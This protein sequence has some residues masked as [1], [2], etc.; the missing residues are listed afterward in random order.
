MKL[1]DEIYSDLREAYLRYFDTA[2]YLRDEALMRER[3][4]LLDRP[5][6]VF[7]DVQLEP[8]LPYPS[9]VRLADVAT[10]VGVDQRVA[11]LVGEALFGDFFKGVPVSLRQH[12]AEALRAAMQPANAPGRHPV[13]TSGTGSGKTESFLLP[14]L[15]RL[16][17]EA[18]GW[19]TQPTPHP[20]WRRP[21]SVA[22]WRSLRADET[23]PAA[24]R[25]VILYPTNALVEDQMTRLRRA[26]RSLRGEG[27]PLWFGRYT[28]AT[29]GSGQPPYR[30]G[31]DGTYKAVAREVHEIDEELTVLRRAA[32]GDPE[33]L[34]QFADPLD[35]EMICRW[36]MLADP[37]DILVT[38]YSM[39]DVMMMREREDR[40]WEQTR[41]WL[42][43]DRAHVFN[44]VVDELH[45][46]RGTAGSEVALIIRML[47]MRLGLEPDSPQLRCL[48]SSASLSAEDAGK[49]YL[50]A[51]FG[52]DA[53]SFT[54]LPGQPLH[55]DAPRQIDAAA[56]QKA[57]S[58]GLPALRALAEEIN[59]PHAVAQACRDTSG[60][61]RAT[62]SAVI[63][64]RLFGTADEV[65]LS[66]LLRGA[67]AL[68]LQQRIPL[69][70]H[71]LVRQV[72]GMWACCD[73]VCP[74]VGSRPEGR[75]PIGRLYDR[76]VTTC[77]CGGRVLELLY[78]FEC[79][80][81]S[82]GGFVTRDLGAD[83]HLLS[84]GPIGV[85]SG[86]TELVFRRTADAFVWYRPGE[87]IAVGE[88]W[89]AIG[90]TFSFSPAALNPRL[91]H[92]APA[93]GDPTG[94]VLVSKGKVEEGTQ[95]P[96]L[97]S[98]C[99]ACGAREKQER[100]AFQQGHVRS[101]IRAHTTGR[102][103]VTQLLLSQLFRSAGDTPQES[104]TI[105]F[106]DSRDDAAKTAAGVALNQH[107]DTLRQVVRQVLR[108]MEPPIAIYE[109]VAGFQGTSEDMAFVQQRPEVVQA[110]MRET[111]GAGSPEDAD[112]LR[113]AREELGKADAVSWSALVARLSRELLGIGVNPAGP[114]A[115]VQRLR[116][117]GA[118]W[119]RLH[120][121]PVDGLWHQ[122]PPEAVGDDRY[123]HHTKAAALAADAAFD[124]GDRDIESIG[125][126][127]VEPVVDIVAP[128]FPGQDDESRLRMASELLASAVRIIGFSRRY[129]GARGY[130]PD[131]G[132]TPKKP[133]RLTNY[134]KRVAARHSL[135]QEELE[136]WV[137][138]TLGAV[139]PDWALPVEKSDAR[140]RVV[141]GDP[142]SRRSC[143]RCGTTHL[144]GSAGGCVRND[145]SGTLVPERAGEEGDYYG[146]L[147]QRRPRRLAIAELTGQTKPLS[148]QRRRQRRFRG[149]L[150]PQPEE[151]SLTD[152]LDVL[153][154]TTT[155]EVG[156]DIGS[157]RSV[158][159]ANV[160]PQR[161]NYQQRV[162]RAG[163]QGQAFSYAL[164][165]CRD[166]SHDD[167]YFTKPERMTGDE[168]PQPFLDLGRP[169]IIR[170]VA[171]S[172]L[173][174]RAF[175]SLPEPPEPDAGSV[176]G[177]FGKAEAWHEQYR[178]G[179]AAWLESASDVDQVVDRLSAGTDLGPAETRGL[180]DELRTS[181]IGEIDRA[182]ANPYFN[183]PE[184]SE[185]LAN[186]GVLPMFGF[187]TKVRPL[188]GRRPRS[189]RDHDS[190]VVA[191]RPLEQAVTMFSPGARVVKDKQV[192]TVVG[193]AD[194]AMAGRQSIGKDPLGDPLHLAFCNSCGAVDK[195]ADPE[196]R[197]PRCK[198][199]GE[200]AAGFKMF[201][202]RGFRTDHNPRDFDDSHDDLYFEAEPRLAATEETTDRFKRGGMAWH[203][204]E[205][206]EVV[207][208]NDN[209]RRLFSMWVERD[210]SVRV[211][212]DPYST[213]K[214]E[215]EGLRELD[216]AAI[217][218]VRP[219]DVAII[220]LDGIQLEDGLLP[221]SGELP[222]GYAAMWSFAEML[223]RGIQHHLAIE[224]GEIDVGLQPVRQAGHRT[225][226]IFIAD[227]LENGAG[228]AV[229][230]ARGGRLGE[231]LDDVLDD[232]RQRLEA[233][234]HASTCAPSCPDC[235]RSYDNRNLHS[236]LDWRLALDVASLAAGETL[237]ASRWHQRAETLAAAFISGFEEALPDLSV[238]WVQ[239]YPLIRNEGNGASAGVLVGHPLWRPTLDASQPDH[240]AVVDEALARQPVASLAVSDLRTLEADPYAVFQA[241]V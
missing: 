33:L 150:L 23:R 186:A 73:P 7:T 162:G 38:N 177:A 22:S 2:F 12:Q 140:L 13:V 132:G 123:W 86:T 63:A 188:W 4:A 193:F 83:G 115:S 15:V 128:P 72:R 189:L 204:V 225:H 195:A 208:C 121:P 118:P 218:S 232:I 9:T 113:A 34:L 169:R 92:L 210:R 91:G 21:A 99:P 90:R 143:D 10:E 58:T 18:A 239:G 66:E 194:Y 20:W 29:A 212:L 170:R 19:G 114:G 199:C 107:R 76:P 172:E 151:N 93:H 221:T 67:A 16:A 149:A 228:Y 71:M 112:V 6:A 168:P 237:D 47:L 98:R 52:V 54:I 207:T 227:K 11:H 142:G 184:L 14:L 44:L 174:R 43:A 24:L 70:A 96:A 131:G 51:F 120:K 185:R 37:P 3:N 215:E 183:Q 226:R 234:D 119:Y 129:L 87:P 28:S 85:S 167:Y 217:G 117:D 211:T 130:N 135:E 127:Y 94:T 240:R 231:V 161:F 79:G 103:Q 31:K 95:V 233:P 192:H 1:P 57:S 108:N 241:L 145:C 165:L 157:L 35:G 156:V 53:S 61:L 219:T 26:V 159:M 89:T 191:D 223:R 181:L 137:D 147:S 160:P 216:K 27:L 102:S 42:E 105:V 190:A 144:H 179:V 182:L 222:A 109:R 148:E 164:T 49:Q 110:L 187:P 30:G 48:A 69:R 46:Y 136:S 220:E 138:V 104:R 80:D 206:A 50:Q 202:P 126:A 17:S 106:T 116:S 236:L 5:G 78:C 88:S 198:V 39:L 213:G 197:K 74:A 230:L 178:E 75:T 55:L 152:P 205:Q 101:P 153:S 68:D 209:H 155:M 196:E 173:L 36:D 64:E 97:P 32:H 203:V 40:I 200:E 238:D 175:R 154:V 139:L 201:Q 166:R 111:A 146:W 229:E 45:L 122:L 41:A 8:V 59:A 62:R 141:I 25:A 134:I 163:R 235:L 84:P 81:V 224:P 180:A 124:R 82:L 56:V 65:A 77:V 214:A 171:A 60:R 133:V 125:L 158:M 100:G 176:H